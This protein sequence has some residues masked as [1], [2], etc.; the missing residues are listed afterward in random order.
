MFHHRCIRLY[1]QQ[2]HKKICG[3]LS[4]V[5]SLCLAGLI[6][7]GLVGCGANDQA[8]EDAQEASK[9]SDASATTL[10]DDQMS[11][12][13]TGEG[14][15]YIVS[16]NGTTEKGDIIT[17][18]VNPTNKNAQ[19]SVTVSGVVVQ[20]PVYVYVDGQKATTL[21]HGD[22]DATIQ[23]SSEAQD[24]GQHAVTFVQYVDGDPDAAITFYRTARYDI[25]E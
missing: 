8:P 7:F 9:T 24:P 23:L 22:G 1:Q 20:D 14:A 13:D 16:A 11:Y 15:A 4:A 18:N 3:A 6:S 12:A 5:L 17:L 2:G 21:E 10:P 19:I 25:R